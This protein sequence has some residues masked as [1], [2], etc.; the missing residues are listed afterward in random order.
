MSID[1]DKLDC[2]CERLEIDTLNSSEYSFL[3]EYHYVMSTVA[4]AL[5]TL[6]ANRHT[7]G[8]YLP[9]LLGLQFELQTLIRKLSE[10]DTN[11]YSIEAFDEDDN[12]VTVDS[13]CLPLVLAIKRGFDSR[14]GELIDPYNENGKSIPLFVAMMSN[15]TLKM[16]FMFGQLLSTDQ[17]RILVDHLKKMLVT[18]ALNAHGD[19]NNASNCDNLNQNPFQSASN[20]LG[21]NIYL[22][23]I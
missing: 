2:A 23:Y 17:L 22:C 1:K 4:E 5:L 21:S 20:Q 6:E 18:A 15:P 10:E 12:I 7:F 9:T 19:N 14:F 11:I 16:N 8:I 3:I 13:N